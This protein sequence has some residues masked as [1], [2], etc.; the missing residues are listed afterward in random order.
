MVRW[1]VPVRIRACTQPPQIDAGAGMH[2][3]PGEHVG[4]EVLA[5]PAQFRNGL[6]L[7]LPGPQPGAD[8]AVEEDVGGPAE[9][10]G[11]DHQQSDRHQADRGRNHH[12]RPL[13]PEQGDQLVKDGPLPV[14]PRFAGVCRGAHATAP[15]PSCDAMISR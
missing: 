7:G 4:E 11:T 2:V 10:R 6:L 9:Q 5:V 3:H 14:G 15:Q 13:G 8:D 12:S 1:V